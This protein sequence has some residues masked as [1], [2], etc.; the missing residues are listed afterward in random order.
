MIDKLITMM[1]DVS[2]SKKVGRVVSDKSYAYDTIFFIGNYVKKNLKTDPDGKKFLIYNPAELDNIKRYTQQ[3]FKLDPSGD[4]AQNYFL[5]TMNLF[6]FANL[7][8][9]TKVGHRIK[10]F[11]L[12]NDD[13]FE[14][15]TAEFENSY[16]FLYLLVHQTMTKDGIFEV[17]KNYLKEQNSS[18]LNLLHNAISTKSISVGDVTNQW[19][20]QITKYCLLILGY[21]NGGKKVARSL[22]IDDK[23]IDI[24]DISINLPGT[25][26]KPEFLKKN[27]GYMTTFSKEYVYKTLVDKLLIRNDL[28]TT[29]TT[30]DSGVYSD[31]AEQIIENISLTENNIELVRELKEETFSS[32]TERKILTK[33]LSGAKKRDYESL[34]R[35]KKEIGDSGEELVFK[36]EQAKLVGTAYTPTKVSESDDTLGYDIVSFETDGTEIHIEVKTQSKGK[37]ES[38]D[39]YLSANEKDKLDTD[40]NYVIY[41]VFETNKTEAKFIKIRKSHLSGFLFEPVVYK[42]RFKANK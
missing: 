16:I 38:G 19:A 5:E 11:N 14:W 21:V 30:I 32:L 23:I 7:F 41:F 29:K 33:T 40:P 4:G 15:I 36:H 27:N 35:I 42:I 39:F 24:K 12:L 18:N 9:E 37:F 25:K 20:K 8:S 34:N 26:T 22:T 1:N 3:I 17:Y 31:L 28:D 6:V 13:I 2:F 10:R